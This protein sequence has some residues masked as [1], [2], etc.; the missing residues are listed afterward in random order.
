MRQNHIHPYMYNDDIPI[1]LP[2][3]FPLSSEV[4][5]FDGSVCHCDWDAIPGGPEIQIE[6]SGK[7]SVEKASGSIVSWAQSLHFK[8]KNQTLHAYK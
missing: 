2:A 6:R 4:F 1:C 3:R 5:G 8:A 7:D